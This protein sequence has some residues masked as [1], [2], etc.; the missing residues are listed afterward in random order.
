MRFQAIGSALYLLLASSFAVADVIYLTNGNVLVVQKAWEEG[1]EVRYQT[2][3]EVQ[4]L[5]RSAVKR[6]QE[7][8]PLP[9]P[10]GGASKYGIAIAD[11]SPPTVPNSRAST[12][13]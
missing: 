13:T 4:T 7:Q 2:D 1:G 12:T 10:D 9:S 8:K 3:G 11:G 5:P 6:I